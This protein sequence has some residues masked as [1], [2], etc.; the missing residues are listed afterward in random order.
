MELHR[1]TTIVRLGIGLKAAGTL[2]TT[3]PTVL[4]L[5]SVGSMQL[6]HLVEL[7]RACYPEVLPD[8]RKQQLTR[9]PGQPLSPTN[10][11]G[12]QALQEGLRLLDQGAE[13][14]ARVVSGWPITEE[15]GDA[16]RE[17]ESHAYSG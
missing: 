2:L 4:D 5:Y 11:M 14:V 15:P 8:L 13:R 6:T 3:R 9:Y 17:G 10:D 12:I 1:E 7:L 16:V